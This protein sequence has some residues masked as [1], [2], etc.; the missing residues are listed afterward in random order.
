MKKIICLVFFVSVTFTAFSFDKGWTFGLRADFFGSLTTPSIPIEDLKDLNPLAEEMT[1]VLSGFLMGA[2][3]EVGYIFNSPMKNKDSAFSGIGVY[4]YIGM[5]QGN[6]SQKISAVVSEEGGA[7]DMF[8]IIDF[9]PVVNF[10]IKGKALFFDNRF[11]VGLGVGGKAI[12]DMSP[13]YLAYASDSTIDKDIGGIGEIIVTEEM[14]KKM[15]PLA[16]SLKLELAYAIPVLPTTELV[17]GG[18]MG[19]NFYRPKYLTVPP[20]ILDMAMK[21]NPEFDINRPFPNYWLNSVEFGVNIGFV[22]KL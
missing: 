3:I 17:V 12:L 4:G 16:L 20:K 22:F 5:G 9:L 10:G 21:A 1:G 7:F 11:S 19:Y 6:T 2:E 8:M 15:N 13:Q 14:M 18:F